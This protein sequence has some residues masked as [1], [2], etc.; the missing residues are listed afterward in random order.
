MAFGLDIKL[1]MECHRGQLKY[2]CKVNKY[3]LVKQFFILLWFVNTAVHLK[4]AALNIYHFDE[5][6]PIEF[7]HPPIKS[8]TVEID[9]GRE[10]LFFRACHVQ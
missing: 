6:M 2:M 10:G 3:P 4:E 5:S 9:D 1:P 7:I 8:H